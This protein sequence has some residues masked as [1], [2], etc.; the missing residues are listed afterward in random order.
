MPDAPAQREPGPDTPFEIG[1]VMAGAISAG[2]YTAGVIDFLVEALDEW[3]KAK[4]FAREHPDDPKGRECPTHQVTIKVMAGASAGGMT[5]GLA[6]GLLG[7]DYEPV[8]AQPPP[9][10]PA[11]PSNNNLYRS[12]VNTI[13]I[14][15]LLGSNDLDGGEPAGPVGARLVYPPRHRRQGLP[16]RAPRGPKEPPLRVRPAPR[17]PVRD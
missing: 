6:A 16:V 12:W 1:L 2:A 7:M 10:R 11:A 5:A 17:V 13:D 14:D 9:G 15:P 8:V 3:E 4:S